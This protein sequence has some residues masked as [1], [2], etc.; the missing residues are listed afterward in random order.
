MLGADSEFVN[1]FFQARKYWDI[2]IGQWVA[3]GKTSCPL[4]MGKHSAPHKAGTT[5]LSNLR[6][7][8]WHWIQRLLALSHDLP[9]LAVKELPQVQQIANLFVDHVL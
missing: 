5:M 8:F 7:T 1:K 9:F 3:Q 4:H 6:P 2:N